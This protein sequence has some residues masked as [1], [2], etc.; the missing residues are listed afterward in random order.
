MEEAKNT[1]Y[2]VSTVDHCYVD[3]NCFDDLLFVDLGPKF[4]T[5]DHNNFPASEEL[6]FLI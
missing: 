3:A 5:S 1:N 2:W 6:E 4:L